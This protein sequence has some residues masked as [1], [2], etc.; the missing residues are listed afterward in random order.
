VTV[1]DGRTLRRERTT[2]AAVDAALDLLAE[3][4]AEPTAQEV[5]DRSGVS[6]RSIFRLFDDME[7]LYAAAVERQA[8]RITPLL[9]PLPATGTPEERIDALV[10]R[11]AALFESIAPVRRSGLR[12]APTSPAIAAGLERADRV[13]RAQVRD[14]FGLVDGLVLE[15]VDAAASFETWDRLRN[16][17]GLSR[18]KAERAVVLLLHRLLID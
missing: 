5:A 2:T 3:G 18:Q 11:R 17:Q 1:V 7:T 8:E 14:L 13:L 12:R 10:A 15:A 4:N 16:H 6:I 9:E